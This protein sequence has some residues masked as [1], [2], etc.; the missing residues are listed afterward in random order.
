MV[1][2]TISMFTGCMGPIFCISTVVLLE[3]KKQPFMTY[4]APLCCCVG[5]TVFFLSISRKVTVQTAVM[6]VSSDTISGFL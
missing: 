5:L 1:V 3:V 4:E 6:L 2:Y